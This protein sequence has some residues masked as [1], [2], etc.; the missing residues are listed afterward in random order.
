MCPG[1]SAISSQEKLA[2]IFPGRTV[3]PFLGNAARYSS[4]SSARTYL[5][6]NVF[7]FHDRFVKPLKLR[8]VGIYPGKNAGTSPSV[9]VET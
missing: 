5:A 2:K 4:R 1:S 9:T 3:K 7:L 8:F 6:R